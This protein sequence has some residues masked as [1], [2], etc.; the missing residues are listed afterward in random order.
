[1]A[2]VTVLI[3][4]TPRIETSPNRKERW[5]KAAAVKALRQAAYLGGIAARRERFGSAALKEQRESDQEPLIPGAF[6]LHFTVYWER[7]RKPPDHDNMTAM[8]K[9][10]I[11]G[12]ADAKVIGND[13]L[14]RG[15]THEQL[16]DVRGMEPTKTVGGNA[17]RRMIYGPGRMEVTVYPVS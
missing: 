16:R 14:C 11:D 7:N 13:R 12:L 4:A 15:I 10:A 9:G 1:M 17:N 2:P 3:E 5:S 6:T 8:L